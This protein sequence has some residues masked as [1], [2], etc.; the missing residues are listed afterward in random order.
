MIIINLNEIHYYELRVDV[1]TKTLSCNGQLVISCRMG[2]SWALCI[3]H[4][5]KWPMV[6]VFVTMTAVHFSQTG[7]AAI[8]PIS[9]SLSPSLTLTLTLIW[10]NLCRHPSSS[11]VSRDHFNEINFK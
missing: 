6:M 10:A 3:L 2:S 4:S 1:D 7:F 5:G 11:I 9:L 8:L